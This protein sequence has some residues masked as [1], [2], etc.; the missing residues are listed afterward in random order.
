MRT[1]LLAAA[2]LVLPLAAPLRA[3]EG[4]AA[5]SAAAP[6]QGESLKAFDWDQFFPPGDAWKKTPQIF[7]WNNDT[8]PETLDPAVMTGVTEHNIAM[9][10]FEGLTSLHPA[11]MDPV[12]GVAEWWEISPDGLVYT[13][14]LRKNAKW[15]N[16]DPVTAEDFRW[17]WDR[18]LTPATECQYAEMF[19]PIRGAERLYAERA[20]GKPADFA[21]TG[22]EV[23]DPHTLRI[24]LH[25]PTAYF[26]EICAFETLM[27]VHRGTVEKHGKEWTQ[28]GKLVG[29]GP[30]AL[31]VWKPRD[32]I[33]VVP[34]PHWWNRRIVRLERMLIGAI[35]DQSTAYNKY[36]EGAV[37][38]IR[39]IGASK[40]EEAQAHPDYYVSPYLGSYFF[41]FNVTRKPF[42]DVRVRKAFTQAVDKRAV[43][44]TVLKAGQKPATGVVSPGIRGYPELEG[45]PYDPRRAREL[46][47]EAGYPGGRG[48]PE[49]ELL[50]NTSESHKQVCEQL[51]EMWKTTLGVK[52]QLANREWK[53]Y[54]E[55]T[56]KKDYQVVRGAWIADYQDPSTF[57]D[58][59]CTDRGNNNTGWSN[60][61]YDALLVAAGKELDP[62][63]RYELLA[64]AERILCVDEVPILPVYYYVNQGMLRP[65]VKGWSE[66]V[67]DLHPCQFV[68]LDG[69]AAGK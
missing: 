57:L 28:P 54:L 25:A 18:A 12:P 14:H 44:E 38:W 23:V 40:V 36:L 7:A 32:R 41:R 45:L 51:V 53:V 49:V 55:D 62:A 35:D 16:G 20:A 50:Y 56:R 21:T 34:N 48:F 68:W 52:I 58:M 64:Q 8:E 65:R 26:L 39:S 5:G 27:P 37:D 15:S 31:D 13:F 19:F 60:P 29:N 47:A 61:K 17:S 30:F 22:V 33:E 63:K 69:P 67:R 1:A 59:W 42:D 24:T 9:A 46:L 10:L 4:D 3:G 43:C 6:P 66:N 2:L 11:T